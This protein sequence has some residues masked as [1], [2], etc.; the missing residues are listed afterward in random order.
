M[1]YLEEVEL[2]QW[3]VYA[4][5]SPDLCQHLHITLQ[6]SRVNRHEVMIPVIS[7][8]RIIPLCFTK[9]RDKQVIHYSIV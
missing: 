8:I 6:V 2:Q 4:Q 7:Y 3:M 1:L 9:E 5:V